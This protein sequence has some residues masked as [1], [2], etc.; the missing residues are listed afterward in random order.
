MSAAA[1]SDIEMLEAAAEARGYQRALDL[2]LD[3][4]A[5]LGWLRKQAGPTQ[6]WAQIEAAP[7]RNRLALFLEEMRHE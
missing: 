6:R 5:Y 3:D 2:L 7:P 1:E 4:D